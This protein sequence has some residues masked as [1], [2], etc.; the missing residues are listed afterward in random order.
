MNLEAQYSTDIYKNGETHL[1]LKPQIQIH[2]A[3]IKMKA[4]TD[5]YDDDPIP[6]CNK[7]FITTRSGLGLYSNNKL[8]SKGVTL[9]P[10]LAIDLFT[11][12]DEC[13]TNEIKQGSATA[14]QIKLGV[15]SYV[16]KDISFNITLSNLKGSHGYQQSEFNLGRIWLF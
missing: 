11:F 1:L 13:I 5:L 10:F 15:T 8:K 6:K 12:P 7:G 16:D 9:N 2:W 14:G 4:L 3:K